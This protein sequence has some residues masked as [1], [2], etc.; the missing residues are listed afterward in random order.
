MAI[1]NEKNTSFNI[2]INLNLFYEYLYLITLNF[3]NLFTFDIFSPN[4]KEHK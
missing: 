1:K 4:K 3:T 2:L